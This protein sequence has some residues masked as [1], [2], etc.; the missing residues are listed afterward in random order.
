LHCSHNEGYLRALKG[1]RKAKEGFRDQC[2][3]FGKIF[4]EKKMDKNIGAFFSKYCYFKT[5]IDH[6][7]VFQEK[8]RLGLLKLG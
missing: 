4:S 3:N 2:Y 5:K 6:E 7:V 1:G 8:V